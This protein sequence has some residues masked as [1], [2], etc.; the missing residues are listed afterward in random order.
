MTRDEARKAAEV[1]RAYADGKEIEFLN[2]G[3]EWITTLNPMFD[4]ELFDYRIKPEPTY[5]PFKDKEECWAEMKKHQPFGWVKDKDTLRQVLVILDCAV[6][7]EGL[8]YS[9]YKEEF[10]E[11]KFADGTP[12]GIK[13]K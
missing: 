13:E 4:W 2:L 11:V 12:F 9:G 1:M 10:E 8:T 6:R 7:I 3:K 5:R